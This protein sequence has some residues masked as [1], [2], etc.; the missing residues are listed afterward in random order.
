MRGKVTGTFEFMLKVIQNQ[1][2]YVIQFKMK[3][4]QVMFCAAGN[5]K[6][7][8]ENKHLCLQMLL[9]CPTAPWKK[10]SFPLKFLLKQSRLFVTFLSICCN[11]LPA[12]CPKSLA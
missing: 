12:D 11:R 1:I 9:S 7:F 10:V 4:Q 8:G 2:L 6:L 3:S 5:I